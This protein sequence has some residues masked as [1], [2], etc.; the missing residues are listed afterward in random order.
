MAAVPH[1]CGA[2]WPRSPR[3]L[4]RPPTQ[5]APAPPVL[6]AARPPPPGAVPVGLR[7]SHVR[8]CPRPAG[9]ALAPAPS[10]R[11]A[12]LR[13]GQGSPRPPAPTPHSA[14]PAVPSPGTHRHR[15]R[16]GSTAAP[17]GSAPA[18]TRSWAESFGTGPRT[19]S[20]WRFQLHPGAG[21]QGGSRGG[22]GAFPGVLAPLHL[23]VHQSWRREQR[24]AP[25]HGGRDPPRQTA[26]CSPSLR[27]GR[28]SPGSTGKRAAP[29]TAAS[30]GE[31]G[32][33][34]QPRSWQRERRGRGEPP[35]HPSLCRPGHCPPPRAGVARPRRCVRRTQRTGAAGVEC[36]A[37]A[38]VLCRAASPPAAGAGCGHGAPGGGLA[39]RGGLRGCCA[40]SPGNAGPLGGLH[41]PG[42]C[43][44]PQ[45]LLR[46]PPPPGAGRAVPERRCWAPCPACD[47]SG[48]LLPWGVGPP[49]WAGT[50]APFCPPRCGAHPARGTPAGQ[51]ARGT[52]RGV[53]GDRGV[54]AAER[55]ARTGTR[56]APRQPSLPLQTRGGPCATELGDTMPGRHGGSRDPP[57]AWP[58][59][60]KQGGCR[61]S[62]DGAR[63]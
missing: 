60:Q 9:T 17:G 25:R 59:P 12:R 28:A 61:R 51:P 33:A 39:R 37:L 36:A 1:G 41:S 46:F 2:P 14:G 15:V 18:P 62:R 44:A 57:G 35:R 42:G 24:G 4:G 47:G 45:A 6:L 27:R 43:R 54:P 53:W 38:R 52:P 19:T 31:P 26:L 50:W 13:V 63:A 21:A 49:G 29:A 20:G 11:A 48:R 56:R 22:G 7:G 8:V 23:A 55:P 5:T 16:R 32:G 3:P 10:P 30:A 40:G 34:A 58:A